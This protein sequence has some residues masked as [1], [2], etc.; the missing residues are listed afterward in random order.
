MTATGRK[1]PGRWKP[2]QSGNPAGR[3]PGTGEVAKLRA[4]LAGDVPQILEALVTAAKAGDVQAARLVLERVL[5]PMKP[6]EQPVPLQLPEGGSL[7]EQGR[8]VLSAVAAGDLAPTQAAQLL[9]A[10]G[11][12]AR[13]AE[14]DELDRRLTA[15]ERGNGDT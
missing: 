5:P 11:A 10:I 4:S 15:L 8:V 6:V 14:I 2:G 13:V 9:T 7:T 12:L 3:K 1:P